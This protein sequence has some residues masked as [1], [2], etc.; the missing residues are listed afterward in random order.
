ML[1]MVIE[2][3]KPG[4]A[5]EIYRRLRAEGRH[6]AEGLDYVASWVD[7]DF[8]TCWQIM[9]ADD[10][11]VLEGWCAAG[12]DLIDFEILPVRTSAEAA[13]LMGVRDA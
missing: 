10:R 11:A 5:P 13:A 4:A 3:F 1:Y 2:R 9:R 12:K 6:L 8:A 7:V